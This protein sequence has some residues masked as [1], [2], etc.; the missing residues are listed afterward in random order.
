[1]PMCQMLA[2]V[3][4]TENLNEWSILGTIHVY[5]S[6]CWKMTLYMGGGGWNGGTVISDILIF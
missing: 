6:P 3:T 4:N 1:M 2:A 5:I